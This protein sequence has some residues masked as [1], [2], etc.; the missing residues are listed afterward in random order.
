MSIEIP[1]NISLSLNEFDNYIDRTLQV[2]GKHQLLGLSLKYVKLEIY[3]KLL[4]VSRVL[5]QYVS[6][7][8]EQN[9]STDILLL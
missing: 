8:G 2:K 1:Y 3:R 9:L 4:N 5:P 6:H 7:D